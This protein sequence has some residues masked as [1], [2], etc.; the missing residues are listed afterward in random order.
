[1][2]L[3]QARVPLIWWWCLFESWTW[4]R[5]VLT[6]NGISFHIKLM[7]LTSFDFA[8]FILGRQCLLTIFSHVQCLIGGSTNLSKYSISRSGSLTWK[9]E[10]LKVIEFPFEML[11]VINYYKLKIWIFTWRTFS[12][13]YLLKYRKSLVGIKIS[14]VTFAFLR[15]YFFLI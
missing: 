9:A 10:F 8:L 12:S 7:E 2:V 5:I 11:Q 3:I 1:M 13:L 6:T 15:L 14:W 4:Q